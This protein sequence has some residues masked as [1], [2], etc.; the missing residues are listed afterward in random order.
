MLLSVAK[1]FLEA[2]QSKLIQPECIEE[3]TRKFKAKGKKIVTLNGSFDLLHPGHLEMIYQASLQGD[4]LF[5]LLNTD[6]SIQSYKHPERPIN[7]LQVRLQNIAALEM[8]DYVS[9][10]EEVN[11]IAILEKI[12]PHVHVNG[13]E[14]GSNCIEAE[15][16]K[17]H[18]GIIHIVP[19]IPGYS[20]S[21]LIK[22]I[23]QLSCV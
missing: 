10:F 23:R 11:P 2:I 20:S 7:P 15:T 6:A 21:D 18:G 17:K 4:I 8:V 16:V 9:W 22:K 5:L 3:F 13:S 19:L 12:K 14:Y 1:T